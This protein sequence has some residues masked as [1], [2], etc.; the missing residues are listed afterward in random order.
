MTATYPEDFVKRF[1]GQIEEAMQ[2]E[3]IH[4][5]ARRRVMNR[6]LYGHPEGPN[7][8]HMFV[9]DGIDSQKTIDDAVIKSHEYQVDV[10]WHSARVPCRDQRH[11]TYLHGE[12]KEV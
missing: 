4:P 1:F 8:R 9:T 7:V 10:H 3:F 11:E 2:D 5:E 12:K 6:L